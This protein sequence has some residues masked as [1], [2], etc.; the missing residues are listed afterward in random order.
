[1]NDDALAF[2]EKWIDDNVV[3]TPANVR[4]ERAEDLAVQC[5]REAVEAGFSEEEMDEV[6]EEVSDGADL[7]TMIERVMS[8]L[9]DEEEDE[10][11]A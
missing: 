3:S 10:E 9:D 6:L 11:E 5:H 8:K 2:L 1:M 7:A 4:A